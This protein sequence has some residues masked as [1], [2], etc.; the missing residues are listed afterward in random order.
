MKNN[1][2]VSIKIIT[3]ALRH[4]GITFEKLFARNKIISMKEFVNRNANSS[5]VGQCPGNKDNL[6]VYQK[7]NDLLNYTIMSNNMQVSDM[8]RY[9][10]IN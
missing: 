4:S 2:A 9:T 5:T 1:L 7:G 10:H 8:L 6:N 3:Y